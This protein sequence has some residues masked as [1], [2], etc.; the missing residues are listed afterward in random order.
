MLLPRCGL[1]REKL[2]PYS[3]CENQFT[4]TYTVTLDGNTTT[5]PADAGL[6]H[7][8]V[9]FAQQG[10]NEGLHVLNM[11]SAQFGFS[12][13]DFT[14]GDGQMRCVFVAIRNNF[15][16]DNHSDPSTVSVNATIGNIS[17]N[18]TYEPANSTFSVPSPFALN[19]TYMSL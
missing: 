1:P 14:T 8:G 17:P 7:S 19:Q 15:V 3:R 12:Q 18:V 4:D 9:L 13:I 2:E 16:I 6:S 10:L 11:S 5:F